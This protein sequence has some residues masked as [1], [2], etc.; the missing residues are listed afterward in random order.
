M[1]FIEQMK[2]RQKN[3]GWPDVRVNSQRVDEFL[4]KRT[5]SSLVQVFG[6]GLFGSASCRCVPGPYWAI[7][8]SPSSRPIRTT[9]DRE[10]GAAQPMPL[11]TYFSFFSKGT[12]VSLL[13]SMVIF[14]R[15]SPKIGDTICRS[16]VPG[17]RRRPVPGL[18]SSST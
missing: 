9:G 17:F 6:R 14:R 18:F 11:R 15:I 13:A 1:R 3:V 4:L 10:R 12:I 2:A 5:P 7:T 16:Y 8:R